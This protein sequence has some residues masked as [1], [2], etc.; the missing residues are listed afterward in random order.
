MSHLKLGEKPAQGAAASVES[1]GCSQSAVVRRATLSDVEDM[2][3]LINHFA[4]LQLMLAKSRNQ[5]YQNIRDFVVVEKVT[6]G[7]AGAQ[8]IFAGCG[9]LH[10]IW[11]DLGE[12]RSL[13]V[14]ERFQ[15][16]GVGRLIVDELLCEAVDL[17]LPRVFALTYQRAFF[18]RLGFTEVEKT[19]MPQKIWGECMNCPKFPNCDEIAMVLDLPSGQNT[20]ATSSDLGALLVPTAPRASVTPELDDA[21]RGEE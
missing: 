2:H 11:V 12:I 1:A 15:G 16:N 19:T 17:G 6:S 7:P 18:E 21:L 13:A 9:A 5:L 10:V 4:G 3:R 14:D 20:S 8:R